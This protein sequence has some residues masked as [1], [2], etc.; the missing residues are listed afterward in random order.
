MSTLSLDT[1]SRLN[2]SGTATTTTQTSNEAG[3]ADRF[4]KL[5]VT[6][7][8]NQDPL[9]P[10]DNAQITSQM[11]QINTVNGVEK[12]NTTVEGLNR[13]FVQMQALQG[14]SLVGRDVTLAGDRIAVEQGLG[15]AGF[16]LA[17]AAD[18]VKVEVL[19]PAGRVV[20]TLELGAQAAGR[21]GFGWNAAAVN[22]ADGNGYR[23]RIEATAGAAKVESTA[24]MRDRVQ[25]VSLLGD[26]LQLDTRDSGP[27]D[28]AAVKAVN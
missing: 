27:I 9:N 19:N 1:V 3:S 13:Q 26:R 11:A 21:H 12:L 18:R 4:L 17:S 10:L 22:Q 8:Q 16:E 6:Q 25:S 28:Y 5:L 15:S 24:L 14:A 23:F 7:M 2:G 20:D